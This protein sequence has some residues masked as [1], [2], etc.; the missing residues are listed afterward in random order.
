MLYSDGAF[1][2]SDNDADERETVG[3]FCLAGQGGG[4][5]IR[6]RDRGKNEKS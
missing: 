4:R 5:K 1:V 3:P 2:F 6:Q